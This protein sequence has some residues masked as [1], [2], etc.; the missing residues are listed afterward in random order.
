M[1]LADGLAAWIPG[2]DREPLFGIDRGKSQLPD[3]RWLIADINVSDITGLSWFERL[4]SWPWKPWV[5]VKKTPR[6]YV[7]GDAM[8]V[9]YESYYK[10]KNG[11]YKLP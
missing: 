6:A 4:T 2:S 1:S 3:G 7:V 9:S 5:Y 11:E 10:F 8:L